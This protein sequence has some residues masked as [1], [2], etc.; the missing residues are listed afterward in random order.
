MDFE[1]NRGSSIRCIYLIDSEI[2]IMI[3]QS[4]LRRV[5]WEKKTKT[6]QI[7][8]MKRSCF[9]RL[10]I[11]VY[12]FFWLVL[13]VRFKEPTLIGSLRLSWQ[14]PKHIFIW[15]WRKIYLSISIFRFFLLIDMACSCFYFII[16]IIFRWTI[17]FIIIKFD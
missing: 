7:Q 3:R 15:V 9:D 10:D 14:S 6:R 16:I 1:K 2:R 12:S 11:F 13:K 4:S 5:K 8:P 17:F